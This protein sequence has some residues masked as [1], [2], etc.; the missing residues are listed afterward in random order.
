MALIT[1]IHTHSAFSHDS[2]TDLKIMLSS[3]LKKGVCFYGVAEHFDYD[4]LYGKTERELCII[5]EENY[6]HTAR[7]LQEDYAGVMNVLVGAEFGYTENENAHTMYKATVEK[8]APDFIVNSIH[9]DNG[10]DYF[11]GEP[12]YTYVNGERVARPKKQAYE[13]YLEL[14][15]RSLDAPYPY[16][17]VAHIGYVTRYAPYAD[18]RM[19][20]G[21]YA[22][23][24]DEILLA[25]IQKN[26]ILE[27][28]GKNFNSGKYVSATL[29][30]FDIVERYFA[31]GGRNISYASDAHAPNQIIEGRKEIVARLKAIGFTHFTVPCRGEYIKIP[32]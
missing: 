16:D 20:Y 24:I 18:K 21:E 3:A 19:P 10:I 17:I 14:I 30:D 32:L 5:D 7:H 27:I 28:N 12:Y 6:F 2:E 8:Y 15:R 29:P 1:D 13:R 31:L 23:K 22:E 9:T 4:V 26:K 25:I 11:F